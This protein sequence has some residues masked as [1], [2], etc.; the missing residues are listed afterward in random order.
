MASDGAARQDGKTLRRM[1]ILPT[2]EKR[3]ALLNEMQ[4]TRPWR[5][6]AEKRH[7]V[8]C[9]KRFTGREVLVR[10]SR[11]RNIRLACP[12]CESAPALWVRLGNPLTNERAWADWEAALVQAAVDIEDLGARAQAV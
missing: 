11:H 1:R 10:W 8:I 3:L 6:L 2:D 7:C 5:S 4:P 9:D 12:H